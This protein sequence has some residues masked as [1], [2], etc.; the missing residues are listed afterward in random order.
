DV[1]GGGIYSVAPAEAESREEA[2]KERYDYYMS[3]P[4]EECELVEDSVKTVTD[5]YEYQGDGWSIGGGVG[6]PAEYMTFDENGVFRSGMVGDNSDTL[7][8]VFKRD[9]DG[10][11]TGMLYRAPEAPA[12]T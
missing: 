4:L 11:V 6:G 12:S 2:W 3:V 8:I 1:E 5:G 7:I 10:T 9:A